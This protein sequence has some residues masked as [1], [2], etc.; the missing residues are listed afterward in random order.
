MG[1][2]SFFPFRLRYIQLLYAK[3]MNEFIYNNV[4]SV[5]NKD[6]QHIP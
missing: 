1:P 5:Y 4:Q 6:I 3:Y 2:A